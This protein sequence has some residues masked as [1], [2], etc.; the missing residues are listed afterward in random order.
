VIVGSLPHH[1]HHVGVAEKSP[2]AALNAQTTWMV[3]V[4]PAELAIHMQR[5]MEVPCWEKNISIA[6]IHRHSSLASGHANLLDTSQQLINVYRSSIPTTVFLKILSL[7]SRIICCIY[8]IYVSCV[9]W[10]PWAVPYLTVIYWIY[11]QII[12]IRPYKII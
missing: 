4:R 10:L 9:S 6:Y 2:N 5:L 7:I 8:I 1:L 12:Y 3:T 11:A